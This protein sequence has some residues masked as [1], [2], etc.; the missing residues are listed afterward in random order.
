MNTRRTAD[1]RVGGRMSSPLRWHASRWSNAHAETHAAKWFR[2]SRV[3]MPGS[4]KHR[5]RCR[6]PGSNPTGLSVTESGHLVVWSL[7]HLV[8]ESSTDPI[9]DR[10][11]NGRLRFSLACSPT[12]DSSQLTERRR[13]TA[14]EFRS[15]PVGRHRSRSRALAFRIR[16]DSW[17]F[18]RLYSGHVL[19]MVA[20]HVDAGIAD[21]ANELCRTVDRAGSGDLGPSGRRLAGAVKA[22]AP[23]VDTRLRRDRLSGGDSECF[24]SSGGAGSLNAGGG[25]PRSG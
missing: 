13:S 14:P 17:V 5:H 6:L 18:C 1:T 3:G 11:P 22:S 20:A 10:M 4:L 16:D 19:A 12:A 8:I 23:R 25:P 7:R 24:L 2:K 9:N 21:R 15:L